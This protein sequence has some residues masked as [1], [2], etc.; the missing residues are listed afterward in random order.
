[1]KIVETKYGLVRGIDLES[2]IAWRGIPYARPPVGALRWQPPQ[3][4]LPWTEVRKADLFS[5]RAMQVPNPDLTPPKGRTVTDDPNLIS[6]DCLYVNVC[7]PGRG[8]GKGSAKLLPVVVWIHG[9]GFHFGGGPDVI[10]DGIS[11]A[12]HNVVVV[13]FNYRLG[14]LGFLSLE[15]FL[16]SS[17]ADSANCGLLDQVA[18]LEWVKENIARFGGDPANVTIMGVSAGAKSV[19]N[20]MSSPR[21][22]GLF[23]RGIS[24]SGGDHVI[25]ANGASELAGLL[26][27]KLG[28]GR[29]DAGKIISLPADMI[30]AAQSEIAAGVRATWVWRP[31]VDGRTLVDRPLKVFA[32]GKQSVIPLLAGTTQFEARAYDL[33]EPTCLDEMSREMRMIFGNDGERVVNAY[34]DAYPQL[35]RRDA[36]RVLVGDERYSIPTMQLLDLHSAVAPCWRYRFDGPTPGFSPERRGAHGAECASVW[37]IGMDDADAPTRRMCAAVQE[38]WIEFARTGVPASPN[39]PAWAQYESRRRLTMMIDVES[40]MVADPEASTRALWQGVEWM[41]DTWWPLATT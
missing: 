37:K 41:P 33:P 39:F 18:A 35:S 16:G 25:D 29:G 28:L 23:H 32:V 7:A 5:A 11:L 4:P 34:I 19:I 36:L 20:L 40:K 17:Y 1:M 15:P 9:G 22:A 3:P 31:C 8:C 10:G 26:L 14:A 24:Q 38:A 12:E 27:R 2:C 21:S 6:E 30:L 13:T